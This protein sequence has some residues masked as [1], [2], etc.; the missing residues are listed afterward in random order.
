MRPRD[1]LMMIVTALATAALLFGAS[2][3]LAKIISR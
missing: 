1:V 3:A 2:E